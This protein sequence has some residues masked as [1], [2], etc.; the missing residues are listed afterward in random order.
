MTNKFQNPNDQLNR[1]CFAYK[2]NLKKD[3]IIHFLL[4]QRL[5]KKEYSFRE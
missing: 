3:R 2:I 5:I 4:R 1:N